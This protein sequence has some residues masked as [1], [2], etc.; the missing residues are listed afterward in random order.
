M[1]NFYVT[2]VREHL[3][4][5]A[6]LVDDGET[7]ILYDTGF[8]FTGYA[9]ARNIQHMLKERPL[10]D[11]FLTHSHYDHALGSSYIRRVYPD[12]R[13]VAGEY[14]ARIFAKP[15]ARALMRDLD[16]K[17]ALQSG[18]TEYEDLTD[19]LRV[20]LCVADGDTVQ[21]GAWKFTAL[22]LSGH[23]RCSVGYY[24][25]A[26]KLLL[27][28][29]TIGV[30]NGCDDVVP[31]YLV[32]YGMTLEAL[33]RVEA[34]ELD[35]ILVPHYGLL[36]GDMVRFYLKRARERAVSVADTVWQM[37]AK[38]STR[39]EIFA[40]FC[41]TFYHGYIKRIY[42]IDAMRLNTGITIDLLARER[43]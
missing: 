40:W 6:F 9:V 26:K 10:S 33:A 42:P 38:G 19:E 4:D 43:S 39:D 14:A 32:G 12:V 3:G 41:D 16:R 13:V 2:D 30:F 25:R 37:L 29:E 31:S 5:S 18:V 24:S 21:S 15:S 23:T 8:G 1:E 36:R 7:A 34:L 20:D 11:I 27:G 28:C 17:A 22:N 35:A